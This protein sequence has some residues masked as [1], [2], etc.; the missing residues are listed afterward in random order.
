[1]KRATS[2]L[3]MLAFCLVLAACAPSREDR[4]GAKEPAAG[5]TC[6]LDGMA[7][8]DYPGPK[9]QIRYADGRTD[10]F[11]DTQELLSVYLE[12][13]E[14]RAVAG[15]YT[16]DMAKAAWESPRGHWIPIEQAF[17]VEG[18]S[19]TGSMGPTLASFAQRGDADAFA[20]QYGG[21]VL[22]FKDI[23]ADQVRLDGGAHHDAGM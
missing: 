13:E 22:A 1:M 2:R 11:C 14:V 20:H 7:L 17:F 6:S 21:K 15:A 3:P 5:Q 4:A 16:Q 12:P 8:G 19:R 23:T 18:S 9:G 10:Y